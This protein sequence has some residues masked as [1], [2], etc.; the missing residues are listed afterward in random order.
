[1]FQI[2]EIDFPLVVLSVF[3]FIVLLLGLSFLYFSAN[4]PNY[5]KLYQEKISSVNAKPAMEFT[6]NSSEQKNIT[7]KL[8]GSVASSN[9]SKEEITNALIH[10]K[11][12][13]LHN[14]PYTSDTPKIQLYVD[15]VT[16]SIEVLSGKIIIDDGIIKNEDVDMITTKDEILKMNNNESYARESFSS[17]NSKIKPI[18]NEVV[19]FSKGYLTLYQDLII[20]SQ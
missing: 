14:M 4:G 18:A 8:E 3:G 12:Y 1:M 19:L 17:G 20:S 16:Y 10:L 2:G 15:N 13:N 5:D 7:V 9:L 6:I 11:I